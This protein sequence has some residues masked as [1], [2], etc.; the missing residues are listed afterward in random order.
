ML[1]IR[2]TASSPPRAM[3]GASA[4]CS[5]RSSPT[6]SSPWYQLSNNE[7][8]ECITQGQELEQPRACPPEVYAIMQGCWRREPQQHHSIK[9]VHARLQALVQAPP[10]YLDVLG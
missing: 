4:C 2:W 9:D 7:A 6:A 3:C 1:P 5:G 10:V 8:I